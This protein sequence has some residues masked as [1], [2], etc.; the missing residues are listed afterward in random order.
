MRIVEGSLEGK[1]LVKGEWF[2]LGIGKDCFIKQEE[3]NY[4]YKELSISKNK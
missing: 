2:S 1:S 4:K 3:E